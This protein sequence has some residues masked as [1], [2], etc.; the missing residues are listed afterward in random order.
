MVRQLRGRIHILRLDSAERAGDMIPI[1]VSHPAT[2]FS[3]FKL[4]KLLA[5][6]NK[7]VLLLEACTA[8]A[9]NY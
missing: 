4:T 6:A 8:P 3:G 9:E 1:W 5:V 7:S 2:C